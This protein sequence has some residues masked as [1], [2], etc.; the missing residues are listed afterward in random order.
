[1]L[2]SLRA[3][4]RF[5]LRQATRS[6]AFT[7]TVVATIALTVGASTILFSV[8]NGLV[9]RSLPV[10][11]PSRI[12]LVQPID[13]KGRNR[14][15]YYDTYLELLKLP[16]FEHLAL[17]SGGGLMINEARGVRAEGLIE[18]VTPGFFEA[19]G[20]LP[21][22][23]RFFVEDDFTNIDSPSVVI[24]HAMWQRLYGGDPHAIGERID[25]NAIPMT[26][27]GVTP[28]DFKGF[29][30]DAGFGF[31]VPLT[32]LNRYLGTD[33]KRPVRGLQAIG[34]LSRGVSEAEARAAVATSWQSLRVDA[35]PG[36]L[37]AAE[38]RDI[39]ASTITVDLL[40]NGF[41]SLR[42]RYRRPLELLLAATAVLLAI[43]CVNLSGLLLARTASRDHQFAILLALGA[44]RARFV[45]QVL[46]EAVLLSVI[47]TA[48]SLPLVWWGTAMLTNVMWTGRD[49]IALRTS[50]DARVLLTAAGVAVTIGLLMAVFP[51][52][53]ATRRRSVGLHAGRGVAQSL[54]VWG[55]GLLVIQIALSLLLLSGAGLFT[56]SL[57]NLRH[58][59]AGFTHADVRWARLFAL[60]GVERPRDLIAHHTSLL[61]GIE[62][63]PAVESVAMSS[64][65]PTYFNASQFLTRHA[66]AP[67]EAAPGEAVAADALVEH[68]TPKF[69]QTVGI[70]L[71]TGRDLVWSDTTGAPRVGLISEGLSRRLFGDASAI[72]RRIRVGTD[73]NRSSVEIV[74]VV[75]DASIGDL[76]D[77]Q[78]PVVYL[79]RLQEAVPAPVLLVRSTGDVGAAQASVQE[80]IGAGR[81]DYPRGWYSVAQQADATLIQER[82]LAALSVVL[83]AIAVLLACI[84]VYGLLSF[85]VTQRRR[86]LGVRLALGA[87]PFRLWRLVVDEGLLVAGCGIAIGLVAA[88]SL[89]RM[90]RSLLFGVA[91]SDPWVL[92]A[93]AVVFVVV[94]L[95]AVLRPARQAASVDPAEALRTD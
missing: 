45:R 29:Y 55:R 88:L 95:V 70:P 28:P 54:G 24:S 23:G 62:G 77:P 65:F 81:Y 85:A 90:A 34:R 74:G 9:I 63:L 93:A 84:G 61:K 42:T 56:R 35:V 67:A 47:G 46:G 60:P 38:R 49:P 83:A 1:M 87:T 57:W 21:H 79:S 10:R 2:D 82:L 4:I 59:D 68:V 37:P 25:I 89:G 18:A 36:Q 17:Y 92:T 32:V 43:G 41:S 6:P 94:T 27:I 52:T 64:S 53:R 51:A 48:A 15:L 14:P 31:S 69:F 44:P 33:P 11:D 20:L 8:Y 22:L 66:I 72:G 26:V 13:E 58:L 5:A 30:V 80:V 16:V 86:E 40:S 39:A 73:P 78:V 3:D 76:R 19:L 7:G 91:P 50:P 12:V 71:R 75:G